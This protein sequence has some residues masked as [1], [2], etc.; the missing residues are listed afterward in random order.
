[1]LKQEEQLRQNRGSLWRP[2]IRSSV[3]TLI[4]AGVGGRVHE[5]T[6]KGTTRS[7]VRALLVG[8]ERFEKAS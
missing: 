8:K 6:F 7:L 1:M 5:A 4:P 3:R 2:F